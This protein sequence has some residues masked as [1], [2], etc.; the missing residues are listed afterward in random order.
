MNMESDILVTFSLEIDNF[1]GILY[2]DCLG[3]NL[4]FERQILQ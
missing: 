3:L 2:F 4:P 1:S